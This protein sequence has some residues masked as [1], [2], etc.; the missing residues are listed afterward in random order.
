MRVLLGGPWS[1]EGS[2][3]AKAARPATTSCVVG[4]LARILLRRRPRSALRIR[5]RS[6]GTAGPLPGGRRQMR[7]EQKGDEQCVGVF[8]RRTSGR[9]YTKKVRSVCWKAAIG[10]VASGKAAWRWARTCAAGGVR[11]SFG[12]RGGDSGGGQ[13]PTQGRADLALAPVEPF[14]D[15]LPGPV[16]ELAVDGAA[17]GEDAAGD[18]ALEERHRARWS[19]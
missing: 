13:R 4:H 14:P 5:S 8:G 6:A 18:G 9:A 2:I 16:A 19:G 1:G 7:G 3:E 17:G 12:G 11:V 10:T 15:A